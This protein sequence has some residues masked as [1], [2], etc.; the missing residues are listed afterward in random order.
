MAPLKIALFFFLLTC[1]AFAKEQVK[2]ET[3]LPDVLFTNIKTFQLK[4]GMQVVVIPQS[5]AASVLHMVWYRVGSADETSGKSGIA[6]FLEHLLFKGSERFPD[7]A[8]DKAVRRAG[9]AHN[10][11]TSFDYTAY[12][13]NIHRDHL[14]LMMQMEADR[15]MNVVFDK[16]DVNIERQVV[17]EERARGIETD[18]G[19]KLNTLIQLALW[20]NH[21]YRRPIIGWR[22]E[23]EA[24]TIE[25]IKEFYAQFYT[26]ANAILVLSGNI[27]VEEA[28]K[29]AEEIYGP[30]KNRHAAYKPNRPQEANDLFGRQEITLRDRRITNETISLSFKVPSY[31]RGDPGEYEALDLLSEVLSGSTRSRL[32]KD[33]VVERQIA[34]S[35][36][37]YLGSSA[38][39]DTQFT[40]YA[41]PKEGVFLKEIEVELLEA[42]DQIAKEGVQQEEIDKA[43]KRL[44]ADTVYAQ[45][46]LDGLAN[47]IGRTLT[48]GHNLDDIRSWPQRMGN[49]TAADIQKVAQK[50]FSSEKG[51]IGLLRRP[52]VAKTPKKEEKES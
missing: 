3:L 31:G 51:V 7:N 6:H 20:Q 8:I 27:S 28:K 22:H 41:T 11:F 17:L 45:D 14:A 50:Y 36:G 48:L 40:L 1:S 33:M 34:L 44:F 42:L 16:S 29:L 30:L 21:P 46:N 52:T 35:A 13:Q 26:P 47:F 19:Q 24:L 10:A 37:A 23:I 38:R 39:E 49:V 18:P 5:R 12:Y 43:K 2:E 25:D 15:M 32:Y 9:G 4:N